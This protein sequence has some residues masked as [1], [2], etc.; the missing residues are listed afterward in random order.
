MTSIPWEL[1]TDFC[2]PTVNPNADG[3]PSCAV[4]MIFLPKEENL[5]IAAFRTVEKSI[6]DNGMVVAGWRDVPVDESVLGSLSKDFVPTIRQVFM[7]SET[8]LATE[9]AMDK[10]LYD[11]RREIMGYF[12]L[13]VR[14]PYFHIDEHLFVLINQI[15]DTQFLLF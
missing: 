15:T 2:D 6:R 11:I 4:G 10:Q 8:P 1:F 14:K 7:K 5:Q 12:R 13:Q 3:S 9:T